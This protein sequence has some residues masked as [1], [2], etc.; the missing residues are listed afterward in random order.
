M[1]TLIDFEDAFGDQL[2]QWSGMRFKPGRDDDEGNWIPGGTSTITFLATPHQPVSSE[3]MT[4][5]PSEDGQHVTDSRK[6]Y[7][8][9][10]LS[11]RRGESDADIVVDPDSGE[12]YEVVA[13]A[14][15]GRQ[16]GYYKVITRRV[17]K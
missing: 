11:T 7:T 13:V 4:L 17:S 8:A 14:D 5:V 12:H 15:R 1:G 16:G 6:L 3:D 10:E 2:I 9:F